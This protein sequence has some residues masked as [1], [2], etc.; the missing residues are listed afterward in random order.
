MI[1]SKENIQT[2]WLKEKMT[3]ICSGIVK[4]K[5]MHVAYRPKV[6]TVYDMHAC[7]Q[8]KWNQENLN[9]KEAQAWSWWQWERRTEIERRLLSWR[10]GI[11]PNCELGM[12][13]VVSAITK[14]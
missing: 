6:N 9:W 12:Y 14:Q 13:F 7:M 1:Q 5:N 4:Q 3:P 11:K 2:Q 8:K 10:R